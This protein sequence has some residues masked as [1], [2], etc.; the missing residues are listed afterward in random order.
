[1]GM[2]ILKFDGPPVGHPDQSKI[3]LSGLRERGEFFSDLNKFKGMKF[4]DF[5]VTGIHQSDDL[6]F[7]IGRVIQIR[8]G[9]G[10]CKSAQI[11]I[12]HPN[13][14]LMNHENQCL[15][16]LRWCDRAKVKAMYSEELL[17]KDSET[18]EYTI[19]DQEPETGFLIE[20]K[21]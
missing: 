10:I 16:R 4:G 20:A 6:E 12:R 13:G 1:M 5:V 7:Y 3:D 21:Q 17:A 9:H 19:A 11:I 15:W 8:L 18:E 14:K 2:M